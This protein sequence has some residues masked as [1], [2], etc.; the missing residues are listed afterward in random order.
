MLQS[1]HHGSR[2]G[3]TNNR[4]RRPFGRLRRA[5]PLTGE[6]EDD[7]DCERWGLLTHLQDAEGRAYR[8]YY[9]G[10]ASSEII[11]RDDGFISLSEGPSLYF[12]TYPA[13]PECEQRAMA[14]VRG[15]VLDIGCGP[16]RHLAYLQEHGFAATGI[17]VS[18]GA[19]D[20]CR[21]RGLHDVRVMSVTQV[22][23]RLGLFDTVLMMG[24]NFGVVGNRLRAR[25][26]FRRF[27][28]VTSPQGRIL[29]ESRDPYVGD[30]PE[31]RTYHERNRRR[32]RMPGQVRL[33][34]RYRMHAT[35]WYDYLLVSKQ[36][37]QEILDGTGWHIS[38]VLEEESGLYVAVIE[39]DLT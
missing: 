32:G 37:M 28:G 34:V 7:D 6:R 21:Q 1:A 25:W 17:D 20:V 36:E 14:Y 22:T 39:K 12:C 33:R 11:E 35:P 8:D 31:H 10:R 38:R 24:N 9:A 3:R 16:G 5:K 18:P 13:W 26:L 19:I 29:A 23:R 30:V 4:L 15:R 27:K 2:R